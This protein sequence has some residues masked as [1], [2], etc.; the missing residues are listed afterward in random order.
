MTQSSQLSDEEIKF[1]KRARR[2]LVGAVVLVLLV[3]VVVPWLLPA[4][5]PPQDAQPIDI[6][7]PAQDATGVAPKILPAPP[8]AASVPTEAATAAAAP[9]PSAP[10]PVVPT[11]RETA[12][13][14]AKPATG[15]QPAPSYTAAPSKEAAHATP[16]SDT[17]S[18]R[19]YVQYGAFSEAKNAAQRQAELKAKGIA[20]FTEVVKTAAGDKIRVR[21]GPYATREAAEK[22]QQKAKPLDSKLVPAGKV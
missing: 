15:T 19:Y 4:D 16:K 8:P 10:A 2:R 6:H 20:T 9:T 17:G 14:A 3:V 5:K 7:I 12:S 1:R 22:I 21:S 11:K 13:A 18:E